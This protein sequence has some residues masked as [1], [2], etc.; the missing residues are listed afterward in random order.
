[1]RKG[2]LRDPGLRSNACVY[3]RARAAARQSRA[4]HLRLARQ[5]RIKTYFRETRALQT[6][7]QRNN[8]R[9]TSREDASAEPIS[10]DDFSPYEFSSPSR[11]KSGGNQIIFL[12]APKPAVG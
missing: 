4:G 8:S 10:A 9:T 11:H 12:H 5:I 3:A 6:A 7:R 2:R 1:M